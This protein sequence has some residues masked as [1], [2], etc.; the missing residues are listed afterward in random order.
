MNI[1][2]IRPHVEF[3]EVNYELQKKP[4]ERSFA[5]M[6]MRKMHNECIVGGRCVHDQYLCP[7]KMY[8]NEN[9]SSYWIIL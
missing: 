9:V 3:M 6:K 8:T 1:T 4:S 5:E 2:I 7:A